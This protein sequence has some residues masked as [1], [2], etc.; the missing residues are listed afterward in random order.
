M[1]AL[2]D[3]PGATNSHHCAITDRRILPS[4]AAGAAGVVSVMSNL[5]PAETVRMVKLIEAGDLTKARLQASDNR[6]FVQA[7]ELCTSP[8]GLKR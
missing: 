1:C 2:A 7:N 6:P 8:A 5:R 4:V 3:C